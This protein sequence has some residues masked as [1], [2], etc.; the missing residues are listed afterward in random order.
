MAIK[1]CGLLVAYWWQFLVLFF[2]ILVALLA[3]VGFFL[4]I[5]YLTYF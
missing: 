2:D 3:M 5:V 1:L 4:Y